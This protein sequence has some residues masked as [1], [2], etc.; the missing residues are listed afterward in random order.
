MV[1]HSKTVLNGSLDNLVIRAKFDLESLRTIDGWNVV[2]D[3]QQSVLDHLLQHQHLHA[4]DFSVCS[5]DEA[6][7]GLG[8]LHDVL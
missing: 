3:G 6:I 5:L 8:F 1:D 7:Q 4:T 2:H